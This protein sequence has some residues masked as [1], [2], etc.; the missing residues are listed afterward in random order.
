M[1]P[2]RAC[3]AQTLYGNTVTP[4]QRD[5][6]AGEYVLGTLSQADRT[7]VARQRADDPDLDRA[8]REWAMRF[9][10]LAGR[11]EPVEPPPGVFARIEAALDREALVELPRGAA[12]GRASS[13]VSRRGHGAGAPSR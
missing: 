7:A 10:P 13:C 3:R 6:L 9:A 1:A 2:P 12:E 11:I 8:I 5:A 4:E